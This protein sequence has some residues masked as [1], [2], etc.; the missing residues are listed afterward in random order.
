MPW[1]LRK[2][3]VGAGSAGTV[4][5]AGQTENA[6]PGTTRPAWSPCPDL[7]GERRR[8]RLAGRS[9]ESVNTGWRRAP[10]GMTDPMTEA[11]DAG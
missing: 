5:P 10:G 9:H 2:T 7:P 8:F 11:S 4:T 1:A 3:A 6:V